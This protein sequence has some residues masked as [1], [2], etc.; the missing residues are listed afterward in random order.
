MCHFERVKTQVPAKL[1]T[2]WP[3]WGDVFMIGLSL[4]RQLNLLEQHAAWEDVLQGLFL[5]AAR[6]LINRVLY[7][8]TAHWEELREIVPLN[9]IFAD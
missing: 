4:S 2:D 6:L 1:A 9:S 3:T 5:E 8:K 7:A